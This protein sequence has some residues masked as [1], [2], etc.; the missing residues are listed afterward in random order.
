MLPS[1]RNNNSAGGFLLL[2]R[3]IIGGNSNAHKTQHDKG[4]ANSEHDET[5]ARA[6]GLR[7][8]LKYADANRSHS[9]FGTHLNEEK[10]YLAVRHWRDYACGL[11]YQLYQ[12]E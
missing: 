7:V 2:T 5:L 6:I 12:A 1:G 9:M 11:G 10:V 3:F 4:H 8:I